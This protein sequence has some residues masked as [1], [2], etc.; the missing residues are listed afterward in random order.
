MIPGSLAAKRGFFCFQGFEGG[1]KLNALHILRIFLDYLMTGCQLLS[2][3][4]P[5]NAAFVIFFSQ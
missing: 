3:Y 4:S 1:T 2:F 5:I